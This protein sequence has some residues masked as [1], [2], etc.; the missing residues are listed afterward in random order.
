[1]AST[2]RVRSQW[3]PPRTTLAGTL[4]VLRVL[5]GVSQQRLDEAAGLKPGSVSD[6]ERAVR[7][8]SAKTQR[9][10]LAALGYSATFFERVQSVVKAS[11]GTEAVATDTEK[12]PIDAIADQIAARVRDFAR[13]TLDRVLSDARVLEERRAAH[14]LWARLQRRSPQ[15]RRVLIEDA[16]EFQTWGLCE[17]LCERSLEAAPRKPKEAVELARMALEI[18]AQVPGADPWPRRVQGYAWAHLGNALRVSSDL[19]AAEDAF[20]QAKKLWHSGDESGLLDAS[21]LLD[22][23]ASLRLDQGQPRQAIAVLDHALAAGGMQAG[24]LLKRA[25]ALFDLAEYDQVIDV[26]QEA[27]PLIDSTREPR[28]YFIQ[29]QLLAHA[30]CYSGNHTAAHAVIGQVRLLAE[31]LGNEL[32]L[33]R[34]HWLEGKLAADLGRTEEAMASLYQVRTEFIVRDYAYDAALVSLELAT[35][36]AS[37]NRSGEV[38]SLARQSATI[39]RAQQVH[40]EARAALELFRQAAEQETVTAE[41]CRQLVTYLYIAHHN[42]GLAFNG[43]SNR[44]ATA[45]PSLSPPGVHERVSAS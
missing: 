17:L 33:V 29:R 39:F 42:P 15:E 27:A 11:Q 31:R 45:Q 13:E 35:I 41:L 21:R 36:L 38:K 18:A 30:W 25:R 40:R 4:M 34:V 43:T 6:Y 12:L 8:P 9:Q 10:L 24:L 20:R 28:L 32:D 19:P 2:V 16:P 3:G 23:E 7:A 37:E 26:V 14:G 44:L 22:L 5:R 1:M